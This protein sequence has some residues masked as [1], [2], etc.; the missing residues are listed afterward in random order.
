MSD[1]APNPIY[2]ASIEAKFEQ[3]LAASGKNRNRLT[4]DEIVELSKRT[5]DTLTPEEK[6][7]TAEQHTYKLT[8]IEIGKRVIQTLNQHYLVER[9]DLVPCVE[10]YYAAL[11][12]GEVEAA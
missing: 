7:Y 6:R 4:E 11:D 8:K 2:E 3:V 9:K 1:Y 12:A 10:A 5:Q